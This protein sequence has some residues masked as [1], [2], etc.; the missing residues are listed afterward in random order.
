MI[1]VMHTKADRAA[2]SLSQPILRFSFFFFFKEK[3]NNNDNNN[4][5]NNNNIKYK[6]YFPRF[7]GLFIYSIR[8]KICTYIYIIS[9]I[10]YQIK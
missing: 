8:K 3:N 6:I 10:N 2:L 1:C 7:I 5:N 4:N 9:N